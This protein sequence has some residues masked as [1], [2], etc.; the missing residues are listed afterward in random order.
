MIRIAT[1]I[2]CLL[3]VTPSF[4]SAPEV[5]PL[6]E[7]RPGGDVVVSSSS[8]RL[9]LNIAV[10]DRLRPLAR[11]ADLIPRPTL[12]PA[13]DPMPAAI[14]AAAGIGLVTEPFRPS[15]RPDGLVPL[16]VLGRKRRQGQ[17]ICGSR[18]IQGEP[19][20]NIPGRIRGCG[21]KNP[22][23]VTSV[24]GVRLSQPATI[25]CDT[26]EALSDWVRRAAIPEIGNRGGG[27]QS[28]KVAAHYA[29]RTR[30]NRPGAK[31]SE[32]GKGR[33]I[34]ISGFTLADGS[35]LS[36]LKGWRD[37][38]V[39]EAFRNMHKKACGPFGTVLGPNADR[40]HQ[41]HFHFDT[42]AYRSGSYCR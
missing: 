39:A 3:I 35:T 7:A 10:P 20:P 41:D 9:P 34:D 6:P 36:V 23:R 15:A 26:A 28:L 18:D 19:I 21:V 12:R 2:A 33:A 29:C 37:P 16:D 30:N 42:A 31:I 1:A 22:V 14:L 24:A 40:Y 13:L 8:A 27:L 17:G 32:H 25:T 4:A 5:S 38:S 11:P